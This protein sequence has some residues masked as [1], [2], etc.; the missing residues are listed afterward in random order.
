VSRPR[1]RRGAREGERGL[2]LST[3]PFTC[4]PV[5]CA[6]EDEAT[7]SLARAV[8][9]P[10]NATTAEK[11]AARVVRAVLR[12]L[13]SRRGFDDWFDDIATETR[14]AIKA[15]LVTAAEVAMGPAEDDEDLAAAQR[16]IDH[17]KAARAEAKA[18]SAGADPCPHCGR[19]AGPACCMA[20]VMAP[21]VAP[22][23]LPPP[24]WRCTRDAGHEGPC[25]AVAEG[26]VLDLAGAFG[27]AAAYAK[28]KAEEAR[29]WSAM[30][31][32]GWHKGFFDGNV[33]AYQDM[34]DTIT[35]LYEREKARQS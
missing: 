24:G 22:C 19:P 16:I 17:L 28:N 10:E 29:A 15:D 35:G 12:V 31:D 4:T 30:D 13:D 33:S 20:A 34:A 1:E 26:R 8:R 5:T 3:H 23:Q 9:I 21:P 18:L 2:C 6:P 11:A 27:Q 14:E 7:E 32:D 25:A